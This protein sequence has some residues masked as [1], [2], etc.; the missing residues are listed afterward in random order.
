MKLFLKAVRILDPESE[1][2]TR[3]VDMLIEDGKIQR[4][5]PGL[6]QEA[7]QVIAHKNLHASR[8]WFD[9]GVSLGEPGF[10]HR[11]TLAGGMD[12]AA[13]SGF[14]CLG[15]QPNTFPVLDNH[16]AISSIKA[17]A[18][19]HPVHLYPVGAL[20]VR[21]EGIDLAELYD[22]KNA[23][24]IAFGDYQKPVTNPNLL[25]I[26]LQYTQHFDGLVQSF[27]QENQIRG[28]GQVNEY[29]NSTMLG[30]K[31]I[32]NLAEELQVSRDLYL[33]EYAGGKLHIPTI[34]TRSS[35]ALIRK[36]K[37]QGL[38]VSC[39]VAI[40][41]LIF[42]DDL[43]HDFNTNAKVLPPLRTP[44]DRQ[45]LVEGLKDGTID[46]ITTDHNP[47]DPE[48]KK[49]EFENALYGTLGLESAFGA[50]RSI[51]SIEEC[52]AFLT[53]GKKRFGLENPLIAEGNR[54]ELSL[55]D[56]EGTYTFSTADLYSS[57]ENS[58]FLGHELTGKALGIVTRKG[59]LSV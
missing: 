54:V 16:G 50:L 13:K 25:K 47:I 3:Q 26:A 21:S 8:G 44:Q 35:V 7:D 2:H 28:K 57:A 10:E 40:H 23:G 43:L 46:M 12:T 1:F 4:I 37:E 5:A 39:G 14:T 41:H 29:H 9:P 19:G 22:M 11:E 32:P 55:F 51:F 18:E 45:A 49:V 59:F 36:A 15:L 42:T 17:K 24:A 58:I 6:P 38:D 27:P 52:L 30:L 20:T 34:S 53:R 48:S 31:G 56:P 33:L